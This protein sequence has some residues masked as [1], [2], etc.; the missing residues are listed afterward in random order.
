MKKNLTPDEAGRLVRLLRD[1]FENCPTRIA[2]M[3]HQQE[4]IELTRS[5]YGLTGLEC[6]L[7]SANQ[8]QSDYELDYPIE[9]EDFDPNWQENAAPTELNRMINPNRL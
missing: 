3:E 4:V 6:F 5:M 7:E 1:D 9:D 8:M 2:L